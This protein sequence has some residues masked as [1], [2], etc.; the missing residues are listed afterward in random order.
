MSL[1]GLPRLDFSSAGLPSRT[2]AETPLAPDGTPAVVDPV[3]TAERCARQADELAGEIEAALRMLRPDLEAGDRA[4][5][6]LAGELRAVATSLGELHLALD[7]LGYELSG[8]LGG[9]S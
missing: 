1:S 3:A 4:A 8:G 2:A 5:W 9:V 6:Q 7:E